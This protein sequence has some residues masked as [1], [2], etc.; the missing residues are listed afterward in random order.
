MTR[1][2]SLPGVEE[3]FRSQKERPEERPDEPEVSEAVSLQV[4]KEP[5]SEQ[6]G[7]EEVR[8][9]EEPDPDPAAVHVEHLP[10]DEAASSLV[11]NN[12]RPTRSAG[13]SG[14]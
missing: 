5:G 6:N 14:D 7:A 4:A 3:L 1:R 2:A 13:A 8:V 12:T 9:F 11:R 10:T